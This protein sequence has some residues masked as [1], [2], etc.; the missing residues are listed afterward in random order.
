MKR[1]AE[2]SIDSSVIEGLKLVRYTTS[3]LIKKI[4]ARMPKEEERGSELNLFTVLANLPKIMSGTFSSDSRAVGNERIGIHF[5][6]DCKDT[7]LQQFIDKLF[8]NVT[9][10]INHYRIKNR[11]MAAYGIRIRKSY[12]FD[13]LAFIGERPTV[14]RNLSIMCDKNNDQIFFYFKE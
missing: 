5:A 8:T 6:K 7:Q 14:Y 4:E 12:C 3:H 9:D 2:V 13:V 1:T 11:K 10:L